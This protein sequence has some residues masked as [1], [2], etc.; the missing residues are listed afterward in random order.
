MDYIFSNSGNEY[1][2]TYSNY[3]TCELANRDIAVKLVASV[4]MCTEYELSL[5]DYLQQQCDLMI[6]EV[7]HLDT[8]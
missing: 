2:D 5:L 3:Y 8:V 1:I 7:G 6:L 4:I